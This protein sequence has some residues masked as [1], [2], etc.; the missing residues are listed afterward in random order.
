MRKSIALILIFISFAWWVVPS[1]IVKLIVMQRPILFGRYSQGHF[2][3]ILL[4]TPI[5]YTWLDQQ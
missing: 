2:A 1:D 5:N 4:L 3:S